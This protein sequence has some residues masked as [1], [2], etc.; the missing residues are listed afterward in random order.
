MST[1]KI[2]NLI[3]GFKATA[4]TSK[5]DRDYIDVVIDGTLTMSFYN[6][7]FWEGNILPGIEC[8]DLGMTSDHWVGLKIS[9]CEETNYQSFPDTISDEEIVEGT[10]AV[11]RFG[12][13]NNLTPRY[14][15][16]N[17]VG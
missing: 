12:L 2:T 17:Y 3:Y 7:D 9:S 6:E 8:G 11:F 4:E 5:Q 14:F 13:I 10:Q 1:R 15:L 16:A